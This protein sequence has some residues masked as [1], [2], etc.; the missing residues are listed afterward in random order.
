M[1][2]KKEIKK[3]QQRILCYCICVAFTSKLRVTSPNESP[4][5]QFKGRFMSVE[6]LCSLRTVNIVD[7]NHTQ[8]E[9]NVNNDKNE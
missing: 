9:G 1:S 6:K 3:L 7:M 5:E 8:S 4:K 2:E